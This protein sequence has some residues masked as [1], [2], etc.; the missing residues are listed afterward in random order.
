MNK[1]STKVEL[2]FNIPGSKILDVD[3]KVLLKERLG[4]KLSSKGDLRIVT[5]LF[6]SQLKNKNI[7]IERFYKIL[8]KALKRPKYR[9][10]TEPSKASIDRRYKAKHIIGEKKLTR[11]KI[12]LNKIEE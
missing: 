3:E 9:K 2:V 11:K 12:D 8:E 4:H 1:V 7:C 10:P 6:R 5:D